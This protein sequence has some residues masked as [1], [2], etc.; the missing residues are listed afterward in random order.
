MNGGRS[1]ASDGSCEDPVERPTWPALPPN[2]VVLPGQTLR[3]QVEFVVP[4]P[5][6]LGRKLYVTAAARG[7]VSADRGLVSADR[8]DDP[9]PWDELSAERRQGWEDMAEGKWK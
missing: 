4:L 2:V 6:S 8:D 9:V 3:V 7:L 5:D 1:A